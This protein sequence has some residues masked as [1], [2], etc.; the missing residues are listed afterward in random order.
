[1]IGSRIHTAR[2]TRGIGLR[3]LSRLTGI[4]V[5][6]LSEL[7]NGKNANPSVAIVKKI[8]LALLVSVSWLIQDDSQ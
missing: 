3:E 5:S 7:E 2:I 8:A 6:Y 1:M 4:S